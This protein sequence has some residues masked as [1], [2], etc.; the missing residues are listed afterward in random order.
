M[1]AAPGGARAGA[2][3]RGRP[4]SRGA[5]ARSSLRGTVR[6]VTA[7]SLRCLSRPGTAGVHGRPPRRRRRT[8]RTARH[9]ARGS[10]RA[11]SATPSRCRPGERSAARSPAGG[12]PVRTRAS[13]L[14]L[15]RVD[16]PE[17]PRVDVVGEPRPVDRALP[18]QSR[19]ASRRKPVALRLAAGETLAP[20]DATRRT[21]NALHRGG[22]PSGRHP[23]SPARSRR[24][25]PATFTT[26]DASISRQMMRSPECAASSD[27]FRLVV[28]IVSA[29][30]LLR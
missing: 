7:D 9:R 4:R 22:G 10:H 18:A 16:L 6:T 25:R 28:T 12:A 15:P 20:D 14:K 27:G 3:P 30:W 19:E 21:A 23:S 13:R 29:R 26:S 11:A 1:A 2:G 8:G 24:L 17:S 5:R